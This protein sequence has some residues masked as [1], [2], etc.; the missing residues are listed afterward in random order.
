MAKILIG[1]CSWTDPTLL[2][3][4]FYPRYASTAEARLVYYS[5]NFGLVEVD[6]TYYSMLAER[7]AKLW[8]Q[9]TPDNFTLNIKAF[10]LFTQHPTEIRSLPRDIQTALSEERRERRR[11]YYRD[12]PVEG[13]KNL[14]QRFAQALLPLDSAAKLG[15]ILFQ[16]PP[17]FYPG[18]D[19]RRYILECQENLPQYRVAVEFRNDAWLSEREKDRTLSFLR[20]NNLV[21]VSVDEPQGFKS[22][23]PPLAEATSDIAVVRFHGRNKENWEKKGITVAERFKYL[24]SKEE[25]GDWLHRLSHLASQTRQL[26]VLFNNCYGDYGVRNA[27][28]I[29]DLMRSQPLLFPDLAE[30]KEEKK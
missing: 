7:T 6:S 20:D 11:V 10:A 26:H 3:S 15:V 29:G 24:Y 30:L 2:A 27:R 25:L 22:S 19:S 16:F 8:C 4:G 21:Y 9:R 28:D 17:W 14:W 1:T 13:R 5:R 23:V 18:E 12:V